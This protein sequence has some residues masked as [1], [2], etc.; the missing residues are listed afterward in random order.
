MAIWLEQESKPD[1]EAPPQTMVASE[2]VAPTTVQPQAAAAAGALEGG[3]AIADGPDDYVV[4]SHPKAVALVDDQ[5]EPSAPAG[6]ATVEPSQETASATDVQGLGDMQPKVAPEPAGSVS[7]PEAACAA[8]DRAVDCAAQTE[9]AAKNSSL[10]AA[11]KDVGDKGGAAHSSVV[12]SSAAGASIE[13]MLAPEDNVIVDRS[14]PEKSLPAGGIE[15]VLAVPREGAGPEELP[16]VGGPSQPGDAYLIQA[17]L[18]NTSSQ[19]THHGLVSLHAGLKA[20]QLAVFF[21]N[22]HFNT[23]FKYND[24]LYILVTDLGYLHER[25]GHSEW[26][27]H[28]HHCV[29]PCMNLILASPKH[30]HIVETIDVEFLPAGC[31]MGEAGCHR[32]RHC[33]CEQHSP[34]AG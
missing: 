25:V 2:H 12:G 5:A 7:A 9:G 20:N 24:A 11:A 30:Q 8:D 23:L 33:V 22:N 27:T 10:G 3:G 29:L 14:K 17:F 26:Q 34:T 4:V 28:Q 15:P 32:R 21:R 6:D 31:G 16:F 18:D 13:G 1:T 19:L